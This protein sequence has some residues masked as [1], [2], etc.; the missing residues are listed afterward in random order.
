MFAMAGLGFV[1]IVDS[2]TDTYRANDITNHIVAVPSAIH[3]MLH[4]SVHT[5][6][7]LD[8]FLTTPVRPSLFSLPLS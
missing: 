3:G 4:L 6:S 2:E 7:H 1:D 5:R 8:R